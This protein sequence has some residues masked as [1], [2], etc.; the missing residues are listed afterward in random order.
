LASL[1][2]A[3]RD[4]EF[5]SPHSYI[6]HACTFGRYH[7]STMS[8]QAA[9]EKTAFGHQIHDL[10][11]YKSNDTSTGEK[12][13]LSGE[14]ILEMPESRVRRELYLAELTG[15]GTRAEPRL[16]II[17]DSTEQT[18]PQWQKWQ[19]GWRWHLINQIVV[20]VVVVITYQ[21]GL[22]GGT[23]LG[24]LVVAASYMSAQMLVHAFIAWYSAD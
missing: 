12:S 19:N 7:P 5:P 24:N 10:K 17:M 8:D 13:E 11:S 1:A 22:P 4:A 14:E 3:E 9:T 15:S 18:G 20:F 23:F 6:F 21:F 16:N 2:S